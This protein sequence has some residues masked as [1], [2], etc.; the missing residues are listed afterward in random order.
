MTVTKEKESIKR[1]S[2]EKE[3]GRREKSDSCALSFYDGYFQSRKIVF[4]RKKKTVGRKK[5]HLA[6]TFTKNR[7][8][9]H[10]NKKLHVTVAL[11]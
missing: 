8:D 4:D 11:L 1:N 2:E 3:I 7:L 5:V 10:M 9:I 6:I